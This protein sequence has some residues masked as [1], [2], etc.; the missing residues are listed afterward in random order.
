MNFYFEIIIL[1][2]DFSFNYYLL[3]CHKFFDIDFRQLIKYLKRHCVNIVI[4]IIEFSLKNSVHHCQLEWS[5]HSRNIHIFCFK[6][7]NSIINILLQISLLCDLLGPS[8][9]GIVTRVCKIG[10][11]FSS[12]LSVQVSSAGSSTFGKSRASCFL[13]DSTLESH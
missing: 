3:T 7:N 4:F 5:T 9:S 12:Y 13:A 6:S 10:F 1:F 8:K 11:I 2:L